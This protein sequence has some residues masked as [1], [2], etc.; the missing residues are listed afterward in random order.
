MAKYKE[1]MV[2]E[3]VSNM[4]GQGM[5]FFG[6]VC[7]RSRL[8]KRDFD[9]KVVRKIL[10]VSAWK[11]YD[12]YDEPPQPIYQ[13]RGC[14]KNGAA[15]L[16]LHIAKLCKGDWNHPLWDQITQPMC[17]AID[18]DNRERMSYGI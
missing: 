16:F 10:A 8:Q 11:D 1:R 9:K 6:A 5:E 13:S 17:D 2:T 3:K 15:P 12:D 14:W 18:F 4:Q 7:E